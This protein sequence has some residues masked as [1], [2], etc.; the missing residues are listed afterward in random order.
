VRGTYAA[1]IGANLWV[2]FDWWRDTDRGRATIER[3]KVSV[4]RLR[5]RA[6]ECEG[7]ARRKARLAA[8]MNRMHWQAERIVE[9]EDVPTQP[10]TP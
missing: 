2:M 1:L 8:A 4:E 3:W 5:T 6:A 7:C 10:E 9:G